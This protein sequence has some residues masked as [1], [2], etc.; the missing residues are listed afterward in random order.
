MLAAGAGL[1]AARAQ[2]KTRNPIV[3]YVDMSVD[4]AKE[5]E[6]VKNFHTIFKPAGVKFPGYIDVKIVKL[7]SALQG[8]AP[9]GMNYRFQL[10]YESE[11]ARQKWVNS[12]IHKKVWPTIEN[13]LTNKKDYTVLLCDSI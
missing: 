1:S 11:E 13:T 2:E 4:P 9:A 10:T 7:R 12:D 6:M 3:L 8:S 5:Q